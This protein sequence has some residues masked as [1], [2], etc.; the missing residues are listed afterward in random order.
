MTSLQPEVQENVGLATALRMQI[1]ELRDEGWDIAFDNGLG[2]ERLPANTEATL[3]KVAQEALTNVRKHAETQQSR[4]P[5][6][7]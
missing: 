7:V 2:G 1:E 3:F 5:S 4:S 6:N